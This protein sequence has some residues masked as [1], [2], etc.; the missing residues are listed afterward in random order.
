MHAPVV[1]RPEAHWPPYFYLATRGL[2]LTRAPLSSRALRRIERNI[3]GMSF[4]MHAGGGIW[5][6]FP[7][8]VSLTLMG[9][10]FV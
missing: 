10:W 5:L 2:T 6:F 8:R 9:G 3:K 7:N 4:V 1:V